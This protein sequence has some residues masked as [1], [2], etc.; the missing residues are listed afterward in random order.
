[1]KEFS[2]L[3]IALA[4]VLASLCGCARVAEPD[5]I[6]MS[7]QA[8]SETGTISGYNHVVARSRFRLGQQLAVSLEGGFQKWVGSYGIFAVDSV[9]GSAT[10]LSNANAPTPSFEGITADSHN[11]MT[12]AYFTGA[13]LPSN[14]VGGV[15]TT[16][17][18]YGHGAPSD[19]QVPL[20]FSYNSIV[21]RVANGIPVQ[22]SH[23]WAQFDANGDVISEDVYWPALPAAT[24]AAAQAL[25]QV[26]SDPAQSVTFLAK[27]PP[28]LGSGS[29]AVAL[30]HT[31]EFQRSPLAVY[32]SY[33]VYDEKTAGVRHF[34]NT[35]TEF[36]LPQE[37]GVG[38][39]QSH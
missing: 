9:N 31:S 25:A 4:V 1:M 20:G 12:L 30:R 23:A 8:L 10:A 19:P 32:A 28:S 21:T 13:G 16:V 36:H 39:S 2:V 37:L 29:G 35:A 18:S 38:A 34:D 26:L 7:T 33:D 6:S 22:D 15:R 5:N 11:S 3:R 14:Q 17:N 24:V 27:L